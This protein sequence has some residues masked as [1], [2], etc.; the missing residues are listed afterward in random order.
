LKENVV[1][2]DKFDP[3]AI[4]LLL[5]REGFQLLRSLEW[6]TKAYIIFERC[7]IS[8]KKICSANKSDKANKIWLRAH[9]RMRADL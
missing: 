6:E 3:V 5:T 7:S 1:A 2:D 4:Q 9:N 8:I